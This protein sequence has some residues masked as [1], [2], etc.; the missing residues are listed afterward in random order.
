MFS[1][2]SQ[3]IL[4]VSAKTPT[5]LRSLAGSYANYLNSHPDA[6]L[7]DVCFT[8]NT[9]RS[10]FQHRAT[11]VADSTVELCQKLSAFTTSEPTNHKPFHRPKI[12]FLFTGQGSQYVGMAQQ[13]YNTH[14][15]FRQSLDICNEILNPYLQKPLLQVLDPASEASELLHATA[16]T[17]PALFAVEY[18]LAELL[19]SW[20]IVPEAVMGHSVGEY[21][22]ACVAGVF[23]LEDGLKLIASRGKL[24]QDVATGGMMATVFLPALQVAAII[25][26]YQGKIAIAAVNGLYNT[27]IS[28]E[29]EAVLAVQQKLQTQKIEVRSL[30]VSGAFHSHL[31]EPMLDA[32]KQVAASVKFA[33]P[34]LPLVSNLT[35]EF[36]P[37]GFIPDA[38]Y[39]SRHLRETV[40]FVS[41]INTLAKQGYNSFLEIGPHPTLV[42]MGKRCFQSENSIWLSCLKKG[43]Q[44][45]QMLLESL[46]ELYINGVNVD[47]VAFNKPYSRRRIFLPTYPFECQRYWIAESAPIK[48]LVSTHP[49]LGK[50]VNG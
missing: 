43:Q 1:E 7:T 29:A 11:F 5:A 22:A 26:E 18:A 25:A 44:D 41:G 10:H 27:V 16:Y 37:S 19:Q 20:G 24:M 47:W 31:M 28:G 32:F 48:P 34:N 46:G 40:Q 45:W 9:G 2:P 33:A 23:S 38:N 15:V 6:K 21:V 3:H 13:L 8:A 14:P 50:V 39:W 17:Q 30:N 4:T 49:L 35:G 36:M 12:A 42:N